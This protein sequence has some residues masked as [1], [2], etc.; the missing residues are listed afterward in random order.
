M[1]IRQSFVSNSSSCSFTLYGVS[2]YDDKVKEMF[3]V[4]DPYELERD[5]LEVWNR[6]CYCAY[7]IGMPISAMEDDETKAE[8]MKRAES[9]L[10]ELVTDNKEITCGW[11]SEGWYDG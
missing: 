10:R 11:H 5:G 4:D 3:N 6:D 8:F 1:K 9:K 2:M 7:Y